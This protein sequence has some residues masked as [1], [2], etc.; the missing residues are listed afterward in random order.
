M[1]DNERPLVLRGIGVFDMN[2]NTGLFHGENGVLVQNGCAHVGKLAQLAVGNDRDI[3]R[4]IDNTRIG[5]HKAGN[6]GPVLILVRSRRAGD[7]RAGDIRA[8]AGKGLDG[9]VGHDAVKARDNGIF[10]LF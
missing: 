4:L 10:A 5:D 9:I 1:G 3:L 2:R 6:I 7:D 8:A